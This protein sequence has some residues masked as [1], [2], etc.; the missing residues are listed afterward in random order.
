MRI[1]LFGT[2]GDIGPAVRDALL[3]CGD[4]VLLVD[5]PQNLCRDAPGY[6]R[7][8]LK[9]LKG[10]EAEVIIPIGN[11]LNAAQLKPIVP[12]LLVESEDKISLLDSKVRLY[13]YAAE[14]GVRVPKR[15]MDVGDWPEGT[16]VVFKRDVSFGGHGVHLPR[17][18]E[19]LENLIAH[20]SP[21]EPFL[22]EEYLEGEEISVDVVRSREGAKLSSYKCVKRRIDGVSAG[23]GP[24]L[25]RQ[26]VSSPE[27][28]SAALRIL[29]ALDY[30]GVCGFDFILSGGQAFLLEANPRFTGGIRT[31]L[32]AGFNI[33]QLLVEGLR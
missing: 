21:G 15:Y 25:L 23:L 27:C 28:E 30:V 2:M 31:Q 13:D 8:L 7:E 10:F 22:I 32:E 33:P 11:T 17:T 24:A 4:E 3:G 18:R 29:E 19:S 1:L 20:Q 14:L 6:R 9:A 12:A 5:F 16:Q 26:V